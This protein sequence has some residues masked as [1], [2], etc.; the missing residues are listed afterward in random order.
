MEFLEIS[1]K[2]PFGKHAVNHNFLIKS[3]G[4]ITFHEDGN[5]LSKIFGNKCQGT[6]DIGFDAFLWFIFRSLITK[7][8][9][10]NASHHN[11]ILL[12]CI[13]EKAFNGMN[14]LMLKTL[15]PVTANR[16]KKKPFG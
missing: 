10:F 4:I 6:E 15:K 13:F 16:I 9:T 12:L 14:H 7:G 5:I 11:V 1:S 8:F 2:L 3:F